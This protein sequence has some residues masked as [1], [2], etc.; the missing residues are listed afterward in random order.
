M[1][2]ILSRLEIK[3]PNNSHFFVRKFILGYALNQ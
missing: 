1:Q 3:D 2:A